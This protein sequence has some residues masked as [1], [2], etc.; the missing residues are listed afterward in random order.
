MLRHQHSLGVFSLHQR[1]PAAAGAGA[2]ASSRARAGSR[3]R[4]ARWCARRRGT[5]ARPVTPRATRPSPAVRRAPPQLSLAMAPPMR[6]RTAACTRPACKLAAV[7]DGSIFRCGRPMW[8]T[9]V[10]D[11]CG[12]YR[13]GRPMWPTDVAVADVAVADEAGRC[14]PPYVAESEDSDPAT[15][16]LVG[17]HGGRQA[18]RQYDGR[19]HDGQR[20]EPA[21]RRARVAREPA[22]AAGGGELHVQYVLSPPRDLAVDLH[23]SPDAMPPPHAVPRRPARL[24]RLPAAGSG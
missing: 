15:K 7:R 2:G 10:A 8:P 20:R 12:R 1:G 4:R 19:R 11:P 5:A 13:C 18:R 24:Q 16:G 9:D 23:E 3:R 21:D 14:G 6:P 17:G 22:G